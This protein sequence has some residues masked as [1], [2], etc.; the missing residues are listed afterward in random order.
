MIDDWFSRQSPEV[1]SSMIVAIEFLEQR[2][3]AEWRRPEFDLLSG[4][5]RAIAEIRF[6]LQGGQAISDSWLLWPQSV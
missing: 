1:Q 4:K 2:P 3:R 5:Y 6:K